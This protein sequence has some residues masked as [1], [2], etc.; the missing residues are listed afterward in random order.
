MPLPPRD[1]GETRRQRASTVAVAT[2]LSLV[3]ALV[4]SLLFV[5][6]ARAQDNGDAGESG[7]IPDAGSESPAEESGGES[8]PPLEP[9]EPFVREI[10]DDGDRSIQIIA[11]DKSDHPRVDVIVAVP[12][13][14]AGDLRAGSFAMTENGDLRA[15]S[16]GKLRDVLEVVVVV[17]TS[18]SMDGEPLA[19]AKEAAKDFVAQLDEDTRVAVVGFGAT[20]STK[21]AFGSSRSEIFDAIDSL[22][23]GGETALY[24]GL[25]LAADQFADVNARRFVV[26][27]SDGTDTAS[28][29]QLEDV[30]ASYNDDGVSLYAI[31]LASADA[32]FSGLQTLAQDVQGQV[33]AATDAASLRDTYAS[34]ASRLTNQY[35]VSY[36]SGTQGAAA[37]VISVDADDILAIARGDFDYS[38]VTGGAVQSGTA[39]DPGE[40]PTDGGETNIVGAADTSNPAISVTPEGNS[41]LTS[42]NALYLGA[43]GLFVGVL[44]ALFLAFSAEPRGPS[45]FERLNFKPSA[46]ASSRT[47]LSSIADRASGFADRLLEKQEK[48]GA[49]DAKL[50]QA[51]M[52]MRPG[53]YIVTAAGVALGASAF[54]FAMFSPRA[55]LALLV[56]VGFGGKMYVNFRAGKRQRM[57]GAQL[58]DTLMMIAGSLRAGH[59]VVEA[60]DTVASQASSPTGDEFSR[61]V[62]EARI[63]RDMVES[64]YDI[65][66][67]T[68][69]EDFIWVVRAISINRELGG[70]LAEILDNVGETIR[71]RNRLRD[72]VKALSAEGKISAVILFVLPIGVGGYVQATNAEYMASMTD[73]TAGK[74]VFGGA[75]FALV[76]GG[77]W[78]KKLVKVEF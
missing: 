54:G 23:A 40:T 39:S 43:G 47:G 77:L 71:D 73:Q 13:A 65:A 27:L 60:I 6:P 38:D 49:L 42:A 41:L 57:F 61:A 62:A 51:G 7:S 14:L 55:G 56:I 35:Q 34:V 64:L 53:E 69:S 22:S 45:P 66:E 44:L 10:V 30:S 3:F 16:I 19:S 67:R 12:P 5:A 9:A 32:D 4:L 31:T 29:S 20:A 21:A 76:A 48:R 72:Q 58:G 26:V 68:Q 59:G 46:K 25:Q 24:D 18:G 36:H 33:V 78:L 37:V 74:F 11:V 17:D 28:T 52:D 63:G 70:D 15:L 1:P 75:C 8:E 2:S 50:E